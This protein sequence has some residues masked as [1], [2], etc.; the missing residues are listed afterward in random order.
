MERGEMHRGWSKQ[1]KEFEDNLPLDGKVRINWKD[2]EP[3]EGIYVGYEAQNY[4]RC[5]VRIG[6]GNIIWID[7]AILEKV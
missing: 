1:S 5:A 2:I 3:E 4:R 7:R 6:S